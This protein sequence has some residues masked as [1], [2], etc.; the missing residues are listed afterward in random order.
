MSNL[1]RLTRLLRR[2]NV[3]NI[4]FTHV[5][6]YVVMLWCYNIRTFLEIILKFYFSFDSF[7]FCLKIILTISKHDVFV[8]FNQSLFNAL[9]YLRLIICGFFFKKSSRDVAITKQ[10]GIVVSEYYGHRLQIL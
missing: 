7:N 10:G 2:F 9:N 1:F 8:S 3:V 6:M 5:V 4:I